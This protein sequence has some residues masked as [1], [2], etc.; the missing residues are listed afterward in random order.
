M[1]NVTELSGDKGCTQNVI[2]TFSGRAE[3]SVMNKS[4]QCELEGDLMTDL[5][6]MSFLKKLNVCEKKVLMI[7]ILLLLL[8]LVMHSVA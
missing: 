6:E 1:F 5:Y 8:G 4:A 2:L 3:W 7:S